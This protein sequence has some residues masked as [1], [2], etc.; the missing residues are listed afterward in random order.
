MNYAK[1]DN[2]EDLEKNIVEDLIKAAKVEE[3]AVTSEFYDK[4]LNELLE[5]ILPI[6]KGPFLVTK[7]Q[8]YYH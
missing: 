1:T 5:W 7:F 6:K 3:V 8:I 2:P 4:I